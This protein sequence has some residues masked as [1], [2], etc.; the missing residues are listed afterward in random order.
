MV[1]RALTAA[2]VVIALLPGCAAPDHKLASTDASMNHDAAAASAEQ[3]AAPVL[4]SDDVWID[5]IRGSDRE[6]RIE[7]VQPDGKMNVSFWGTEMTTD[8]NLNIIV[9]R[10]LTEAA[11]DPTISNKPELW[12]AFPLYPGKSWVNDY[13][14]KITGASATTGQAEDKGQV[15]GWED[16]TVPAGTFHC[17]KVEV[18]SRFFGKGG[19]FDQSQ[20][21]YWYAP[22]VNRFVK[23]DYHSNYEGTVIAELAEYKPATIH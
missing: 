20:L 11:S 9:Y 5:R 2:A 1:P 7:S 4:H 22:K 12:F 10:S 23:F 6:F 21:T 18:K 15:L 19:M 13:T 3:V 16:V 8:P 14:W 17:L